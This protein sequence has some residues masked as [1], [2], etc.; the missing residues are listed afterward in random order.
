MGKKRQNQNS[1]DS[2]ALENWKEVELLEMFD[3]KRI[4]SYQTPLMK[5]WLD[6]QLPELNLAE[7]HL[8]DAIYELALDNIEFWDKQNLKMKFIW[9]VLYLGYMR[10]DSSKKLV[11][12]FDKTISATVD[13]IPLKVESDYMLSKGIM[14]LG[15]TPYFHFQAYEPYIKQAGNPMARLLEAFLIAQA[16][17]QNGK[18]LY[19]VEIVGK[20]WTFVTMEGKEYCISNT[21]E[22]TKKNDLLSII[23]ILRKFRAI[24]YER[25][26]D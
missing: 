3:L 14:N 18:P 25:L 15:K 21:Y 8:F 10:D 13:S 6:V 19:G 5:E 22:A 16:K 20:H 26:L 24:L 11:S 23:A 12:F 17:N 2:G 4:N 1:N 9:A 7:Q